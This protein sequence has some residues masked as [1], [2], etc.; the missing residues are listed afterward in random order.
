M[1]AYRKG[2][3]SL[4]PVKQLV[5]LTPYQQ[6]AMAWLIHHTNSSGKCF[7][8]L[9]KLVEETG[10]G[11]TK[12]VTV[13]KE[14]A[15]MG[16]ISKVNRGSASGR[17]SNLY[18]VH[19]RQPK[20]PLR[21]CGDINPDREAVTNYIQLEQN[22][23]SADAEESLESG[24]EDSQSPALPSSTKESV[25]SAEQA[26]INEIWGDLNGE[27]RG[28][29]GIVA[30]KKG[31]Y[32]KFFKEVDDMELVRKVF[33]YLRSEKN[34]TDPFGWLTAAYN[35]GNLR[36]RWNSILPKVTEQAKAIGKDVCPDFV[37]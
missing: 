21:P 19:K 6:V 18:T 20:L 31:D 9:K 5:G 22:P 36:N 35:V 26:F 33:A 30:S 28:R 23:L 3:F 11:K 25:V 29:G 7:P 17:K 8:S 10:I 24:E 12:L 34:L 2:E 14:L 16:L 13:L 15:E 1:S 32:V 4:F 37:N 27:I